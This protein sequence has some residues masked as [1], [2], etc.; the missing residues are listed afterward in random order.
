[1][2]ALLASLRAK[3]LGRDECRVIVVGL[4]GSGKTTIVHRLKHGKLDESEIIRATPPEQ[5]IL[6]AAQ[7]SRIL[8]RAGSSFAFWQLSTRSNNRVQ[9]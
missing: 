5:S 3:F 7:C 9:C 2:A 6:L 8:Q 1:M 4:D